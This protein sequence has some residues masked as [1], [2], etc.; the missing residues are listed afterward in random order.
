MSRYVADLNKISPQQP[1]PANDFEDD[2]NFF[3]TGEFFDFDMGDSISSLPAN[4]FDTQQAANDASNTIGFQQNQ[5]SSDFLSSTFRP[6]N[7][8]ILRSQ[9]LISISI[10]TFTHL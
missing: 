6:L 7:S 3:T 2:L 8:E 9:V 10:A 4:D 1:P 5:T